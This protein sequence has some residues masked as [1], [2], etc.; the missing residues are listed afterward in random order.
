MKVASSKVAL[1]HGTETLRLVCGHINWPLET[2]RHNPTKAPALF[3]FGT[4]RCSTSVTFELFCLVQ[5]VL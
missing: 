2:K 5:E 4:L 3:V 1:Q